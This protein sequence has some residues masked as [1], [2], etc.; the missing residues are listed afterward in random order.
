MC[1]SYL[2]TNAILYKGFEHLW[3]LISVG[4][5]ELISHGYQG[6]QRAVCHQM[7]STQI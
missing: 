5:L 2:Q 6:K 1:L 7:K 4:V 3:I